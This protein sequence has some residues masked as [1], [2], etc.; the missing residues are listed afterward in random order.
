MPGYFLSPP[1]VHYLVPPAPLEC[2]DTEVAFGVVRL[3]SEAWELEWVGKEPLQG[4]GTLRVGP[5]PK[6]VKL[7]YRAV[8]GAAGDGGGGGG[9]AAAAGG[10]GAQLA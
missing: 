3:G 1:G 2:G 6:G 5:W 8:V 7:P 4:S 10:G 9:A